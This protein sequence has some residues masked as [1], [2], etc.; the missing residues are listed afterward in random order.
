VVSI[1]RQSSQELRS[2][3][4]K[5]KEKQGTLSPLVIDNPSPTSKIVLRPM[6]YVAE[7]LSDSSSFILSVADSTVKQD[8]NFLSPNKISSPQLTRQ[9]STNCQSP[10]NNKLTINVE[11]KS[12]SLKDEQ[13][14]PL[15]N[16]DDLL[17]NIGSPNLKF[18]KSL[19]KQRR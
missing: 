13:H 2:I 19:N 14:T 12:P 5:F 10:H 17:N 11:V 8:K 9:R 4:R 7:S 3:K 6:H 1:I 15:S 16:M 18:K